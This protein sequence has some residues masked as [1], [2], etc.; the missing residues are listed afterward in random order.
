MFALA[1]VNGMLAAFG[2]LI[3]ELAVLVAVPDNVS[4]LE[5]PIGYDSSVGMIIA[6]AVIEEAF[7]ALFV[8]RTLNDRKAVRKEFLKAAPLIG[9]GFFLIELLFKQ[10]LLS[11]GSAPYFLGAFLL[12]SVTV[13]AFAWSAKRNA[14]GRKAVLVIPLAFNILLHIAYNLMIVGMT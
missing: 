8:I 1:F 6:A 7:K 5:K 9:I 4:S 3:A 14:S 11:A 13:L 2:S 10:S 12:H